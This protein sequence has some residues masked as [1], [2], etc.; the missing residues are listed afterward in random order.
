MGVSP[1]ISGKGDGERTGIV[2]VVFI[3]EINPSF[4]QG[5]AVRG[6]Q[7]ASGRLIGQGTRETLRDR[8]PAP[9]L[10][11]LRS[12]VEGCGQD[13]EGSIENAGILE[14]TIDV[15]AKGRFI[16]ANGST[17]GRF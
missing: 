8:E 13:L 10:G 6:R 11:L 9:A 12:G 4:I 17:Q 2:D 14:G 16:N 5:E 1:K 15:L 7:R 3:Q